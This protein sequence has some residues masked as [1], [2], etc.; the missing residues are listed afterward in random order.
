MRC[1]MIKQSYLKVCINI[2]R[3]DVLRLR[4]VLAVHNI[5]VQ[6]PFLY[7]QQKQKRILQIR[8]CNTLF[9]KIM[10]QN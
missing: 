9:N 10:L 4:L 7:L 6:S 2:L 5:H 1:K 8:T 3:H